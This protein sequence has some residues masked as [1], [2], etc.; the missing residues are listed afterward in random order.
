MMWS[1]R[2]SR[3]GVRVAAVV[4][5]WSDVSLSV[6]EART[7]SGP[8]TIRG[9]AHSV[10]AHSFDLITHSQGR[11]R[12]ELRP[13]TEIREK[14]R[15]STSSVRDGEHVGVRGYL[16]AGVLTAIRVTI[17]PVKAKPFTVTGVVV[18]ANGSTVTVKS[19]AKTIIL[20]LWSKTKVRVGSRPGVLSQLRVGDKISARV[21]G[22][23]TGIV[24]TAI[25]VYSRTAAEHHV[26]L[27]GVLS[28]VS[29]SAI[30]VTAAGARVTVLVSH[31]T[32]VY[33]GRARVGSRD[34]VS[35]QMVVVHACCAGKRLVAT[36][37]H[38]R[39][40]IAHVPS[41]TV[42][43]Q[44]VAVGRNRLTLKTSTGVR[45]V[46]L[47]SS[48]RF[49]LGAKRI[50][51]QDLRVGDQVSARGQVSGGV[52]E[53]VRVHVYPEYRQVRHISGII[54]SISASSFVI[55]RGAKRYIAVADRATAVF[56]S[57]KPVPYSRLQKGERVKVTGRLLAP[58]QIEARRID[59]RPIPLKTVTLH[60][61][62]SEIHREGFTLVDR[63][64]VQHKVRL[65]RGT[66]PRL[67]GLPAPAEAFFPGVLVTVKA[68]VSGGEV[69]ATLVTLHVVQRSV[70]GR[71]ISVRGTLLSLRSSPS[72]A[73]LID[74]P[75]HD[76]IRDGTRHLTLNSIGIGAYLQVTGYVEAK[77]RLR[78]AE[79]KV[80]HPNLDITG[81]VV[82]VPPSLVVETGTGEKFK[83][84][85]SSKVDVVTSRSHVSIVPRDIPLQARVRI[86]GMMET[87]GALTAHAIF[88]QLQ[89][90]SVRGTVIQI[91]G[92]VVTMHVDS[93]MMRL[94]LLDSAAV[95]Q[96]KHAIDI[97]DVVPGDSV[98]AYGYVTAG[99][100]LVRKLEVHRR[101][102]GVEGSVS[103]LTP[104][105]FL[106]VTS[107]GVQR[108]IV[109]P[110]L[111]VS[112]TVQSIGV[113]VRV[114]V[115]GYRRGD[116]VILA[117][118]LRTLKPSRKGTPTP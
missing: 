46:L 68:S 30:V 55:E 52:L 76:S 29:G 26:V 91:A 116:G 48:T 3:T 115:S 63:H 77:S 85:L 111:P 11:L 79:V 2:V 40:T 102:V 59:A 53:A 83:I 66:H 117:T 35:G 94:Q 34:L 51:P 4:L 61:V 56:M 67:H 96:G 22:T 87:D 49:E 107:D 110:G 24:V 27:R 65:A 81:T 106:L 7:K 105:G 31:R 9:V 13:Q 25:R 57:G 89:S 28:R 112:G 58:N 45:D 99:D 17:Y 70:L 18:Q 16:H 84:R 42:K 50:H 43:G 88:V 44:V 74:V 41:V 20:H 104:D 60:G 33:R 86:Q 101:I 64:G 39:M 75:P 5:L 100:V 37:I 62:V 90:V 54:A 113:G 97:R 93:G 73:E 103:A 82:G 6:A 14:G 32:M 69:S 95:T 92:S 109:S 114:H 108:V 78:A 15:K 36:S 1:T 38:I 23:S 71:V 118:R 72:R 80:A 8:V 19:G 12:V 47:G 10:T 98:T 21:V